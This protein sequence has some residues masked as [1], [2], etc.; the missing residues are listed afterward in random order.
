M[1]LLF[2][3]HLLFVGTVLSAQNKGTLDAKNP[4]I[5]CL[6]SFIDTLIGYDVYKSGDTVFVYEKEYLS[7][8]PILHSGVYIKVI[9]SKLLYQKT[10]KRKPVGVVDVQALR[11]DNEVATINIVDF[12][13]ERRKNHYSRINSGFVRYKVFFDCNT[14]QYTYEVI[15]SN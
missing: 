5:D 12:G 7:N 3:L 14:R 15:A 9:D 2:L 13:V 1:K 6:L 8:L 11:F 4:Y 10:K